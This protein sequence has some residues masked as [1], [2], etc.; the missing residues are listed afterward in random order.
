MRPDGV[1]LSQFDKK[2]TAEQVVAGL[3]L[4][5]KV[6][7]ITGATSGLGQESMRVLAAHGARVL[8]TGRTLDKAKAACAAI[9]AGCEPF[10]LELES[11]DSI[12]SCAEQVRAL[13]AP[14]DILMC[15]AGIMALP[16][17][18][19][20]NGIEKHFA[21]NHLGHF[22]LVNL[23]LGQVQAAPQGRIVALSSSA[24]K[25]A[26]PAGIEFD[27]LAG[28]RDYTPNKAYGQSKTANGLFVMQLAKR[29]AGGTATANAVNPGAVDTNLPRHYPGWQRA[30]LGVISGFLL[31]PVSVGASTQCYVATAPALAKVSGHYFDECNPLVPGGQMQNAALAEKLWQVST[32]LCGKYLA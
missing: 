9:G 5:G 23:L 12:R 22:L 10:E 4:N 31:K 17:L 25:W 27:N 28:T 20:V 19:Q 11:M 7:L 13:G 16:Q 8:A 1:P 32:D 29:L 26:P 30:I 2:S 15:N 6:V 24:Y 14:I 21:V 3:D 18:E